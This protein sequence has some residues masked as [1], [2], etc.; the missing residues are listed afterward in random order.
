MK[1]RMLPTISVIVV[2]ALV[3]IRAKATDLS[4]TEIEKVMLDG[5]AGQ[6][7]SALRE[8]DDSRYTSIVDLAVEY[9]NNPT[10]DKSLLIRQTKLFNEAL[11]V[12]A[13]NA[14][15]L[16]DDQLKSLIDGHTRIAV[17]LLPDTRSC[18]VYLARGFKFVPEEAKAKI[19]KRQ[20]AL[21]AKLLRDLDAAS[22]VPARRQI[23]NK[24]HWRKT[25]VEWMQT[26]A[27]QTDLD[28]FLASNS[29]DAEYCET[30]VSLLRHVRMSD[31]R[32]AEVARADLVRGM[33][34]KK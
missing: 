27:T 11:S 5:D 12:R 2:L 28:R 4:R 10:V 16:D 30:A 20:D 21:L 6:L 25:V 18:G 15:A 22:T 1:F 19:A 9:V 13:D 33:A 34:A 14:L 31:S 23:T 7:L 3:P 32:A 24:A 26:G 17:S 29:N 8:V